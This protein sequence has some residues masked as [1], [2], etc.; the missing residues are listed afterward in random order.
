MS[1]PALKA[2]DGRASARTRDYYT[3]ALR[4]YHDRHGELTAACFSPGSAKRGG[5]PDLVE[6]YYAPRADGTAWPSLNSIK[7]EFGGSFNTARAAVGLAPS[8][9]GPAS[10]RRKAGKAAPILDVRERVV[11]I[12]VPS[13][14]VDATRREARLAL[15]R[16]ARQRARADRLEAELRELRRRG[17]EVHERVV[18]AKPEV[19]TVTKTK[20]VRVRD[21]R[22]LERARARLADEQA[23]RRALAEQLRASERELNRARVTAAE[24]GALAHQRA[25]DADGATQTGA[26]ASDRL[27]AAERLTLRLRGELDAARQQLLG[28][29]E[30]AAVS[31]LVRAADR[32]ADEAEVRAARAEREMAEQGAAVTGQLRQLTQDEIAELRRTGPSGPAVMAAALKKLAAAR[33]LGGRDRMD[34]A[35]SEVMMAARGYKDTL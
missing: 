35:L 21:D 11:R 5:R 8:S 15:D 7:A 24:Q 10:G 20:K 33:S 2:G 4:E 34:R 26:R 1:M 12:A 13:Q 18:A 22:A 14:R 17:P 3:A 25:L 19:R 28:A 30:A 31:D 29:T 16:E 6:R 32:R 9:T 23:A 27:A